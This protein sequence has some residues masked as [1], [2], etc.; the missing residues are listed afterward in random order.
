[1]PDRQRKL[2]ADFPV[3]GRDE[4]SRRFGFDG[5]PLEEARN[6]D[7]KSAPSGRPD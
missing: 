4:H 3:R 2:A 7:E 5:L 6:A 1:M